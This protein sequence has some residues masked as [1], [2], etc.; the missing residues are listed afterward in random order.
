MTFETIVKFYEAVGPFGIPILT[1]L[2]AYNRYLGHRVDSKFHKLREYQKRASEQT[3]NSAYE[4]DEKIMEALTR[5][6]VSIKTGRASPKL[7]GRYGITKG[8]A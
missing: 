8:G 4:R 1:L 7:W 6:G 2:W 5:G 3:L